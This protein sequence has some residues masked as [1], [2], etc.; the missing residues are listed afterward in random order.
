VE[1][2]AGVHDFLRNDVSRSVR[3]RVRVGVIAFLLQVV[4]A[5]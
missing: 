4:T 2:S 5:V 1:F 3:V